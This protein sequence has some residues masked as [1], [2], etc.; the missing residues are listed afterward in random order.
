MRSY[1]NTQE[2]NVKFDNLAREYSLTRS[3]GSD[4]HGPTGAFEIG[5]YDRPQNQLPKDIL[6]ELWESLPD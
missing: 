5:I 4:Y 1:F 6:K 3:G 2:Q